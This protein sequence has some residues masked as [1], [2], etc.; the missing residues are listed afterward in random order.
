VVVRQNAPPNVESW[1]EISK[2]EKDKIIALLKDSFKVRFG[3]NQFDEENF[4]EQIDEVLYSELKRL[5]RGCRYRLHK[6]FLSSVSLNEAIARRPPHEQV[7]EHQSETLDK[8][9]TMTVEDIFDS[10]L[11]PKSGYVRGLGAEKA[12]KRANVAEKKNKELSER[13]RLLENK[14]A[15]LETSCMERIRAELQAGLA[16]IQRNMP[17]GIDSFS[18]T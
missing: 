4:E 9:T 6:H 3:K 8:D 14:Q 11:P 15:S 12:R 5:Y 1:S 2:P 10:V 13:I 7:Y 16:A 18:D 17:G